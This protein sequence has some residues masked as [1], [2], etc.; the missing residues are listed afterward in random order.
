[1]YSRS[2]YCCFNELRKSLAMLL[3][4]KIKMKDIDISQILG[5][6][7]CFLGIVEGPGMMRWV[8]NCKMKYF[9]R[10][11]LLIFW[12]SPFNTE[13]KMHFI[14]MEADIMI[15]L[16]LFTMFHRNL[17]WITKPPLRMETVEGCKHS[18]AWHAHVSCFRADWSSDNIWRYQ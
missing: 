2:S 1:M 10:L 7:D 12:R 14:P 18:I 11:S 5:K 6:Q 15:S 17:L 16:H 4:Q 8:S 3:I 9:S 13:T